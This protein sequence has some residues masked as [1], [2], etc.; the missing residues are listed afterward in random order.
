MAVDPGNGIAHYWLIYSMAH[1]GA[2]ELAKF[3]VQIARE[4]L[5][6]EEYYDLV[7]ALKKTR[8]AP[9]HNLFR[10]EK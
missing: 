10:K 2:G 1:R 8:L 7:S 6:E 4:H 9:V 3:Q 5:T